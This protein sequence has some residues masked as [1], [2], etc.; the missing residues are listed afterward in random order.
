MANKNQTRIRA[1][2][3]GHFL[4]DQNGVYLFGPLNVSNVPETFS[5]NGVNT[6]G[7]KNKTAIQKRSGNLP[8][9]YVSIARAGYYIGTELN[10][11]YGTSPNRRI[12]SGSSRSKFGD[13]CSY[14]RTNFSETSDAWNVSQEMIRNKIR[15]KVLD[16]KVNLAQAL[17]E[18]KQT[19]RLLVDSV[20]RIGTA[21]VH[22]RKGKLRSFCYEFGIPLKSK[23]GKWTSRKV[24]R[25]WA[26][27]WL[28]YKYGWLPLMMDVHGSAEVLA[29]QA[30]QR[31]GILRT[32]ARAK[33]EIN[34]SFNR[35]SAI[36]YEPKPGA[37]RTVTYQVE[38]KATGYCSFSLN[39][40]MPSLGLGNPALLAWELIPFSFV[41]DWFLG[42]GNFLQ[43]INALEGVTI[44]KAG[45]SRKMHVKMKDVTP[46]GVDT[47]AFF[48][49]FER[50]TLVLD[51]IF[52]TFI[53]ENRFDFIK[54]ITSVALV[55]QLLSKSP[56]TVK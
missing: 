27:L 42:V 47:S 30:L 48:Q 33:E 53:N 21:L 54:F 51:G 2:S 32:K 12:V 19:E 40:P 23:H 6:P 4:Q 16:M 17:G 3:R 11:T 20:K 5:Q 26:S 35:V 50:T 13:P 15:E 38:L 1:T 52:S 44:H 56:T 25:Q 37:T 45:I 31:E 7:W 29:Q 22:L 18:R 55:R 14:S 10:Y 43:G 24:S 39:D 41:A 36:A 34:F 9:N 8:N 49:E 46:Y 28:E